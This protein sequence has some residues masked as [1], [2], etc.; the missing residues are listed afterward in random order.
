VVVKIFFEVRRGVGCG[1]KLIGDVVVHI[2][3]VELIELDEEPKS[4]RVR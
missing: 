1:E 2:R 3:F 4:I